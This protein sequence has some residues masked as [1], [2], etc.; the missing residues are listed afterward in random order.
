MYMYMYMHI[1]CNIIMLGL[2]CSERERER[3]R[4]RKVPCQSRQKPYLWL[5]LHSQMH[6]KCV[7]TSFPDVLHGTYCTAA[8][9]NFTSNNSQNNTHKLFI[10]EIIV[11]ILHAAACIYMY[12]YVIIHNRLINY[13]TPTSACSNN[14][15]T[16]TRTQT[17]LYIYI[18]G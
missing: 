18:M 15:Y 1:P 9:I 14:T 4:K 12:M 17:P 11:D 5:I 2:S 10:S 7:N 8:R 13:H 6:T 3:E 16:R